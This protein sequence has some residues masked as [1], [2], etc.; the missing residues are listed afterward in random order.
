MAAKR[1]GAAAVVFDEAG[2]VLL[3]QHSYGKRN[4]E[5]PGGG[6][7][8]QESAEEAARREL[9]E[10]T[11]LESVIDRLTGVYYDPQTDM[12][13]FAFI[14]TLRGSASPRP[15]SPEILECGY[16]SVEELPV[17]ISDFTCLRIEEASGS[18]SVTFHTIGPR[19]WKE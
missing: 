16:F 6:A 7:E 1:I 3:V 17:P 5:L 10:E 15:M 19:R 9:L 14:A 18:Q 8:E 11:G 2:R 4:W 13:H 12:H